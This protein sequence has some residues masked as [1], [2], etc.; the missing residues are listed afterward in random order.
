MPAEQFIFQPQ[1]SGSAVCKRAPETGVWACRRWECAREKADK[2]GSQP[3]LNTLWERS[4]VSIISPLKSTPKIH[5]HPKGN[6]KKQEGDRQNKTVEPANNHKAPRP[7]VTNKERARR[8]DVRQVVLV[9]EI[10]VLSA[11]HFTS[12]CLQQTPSSPLHTRAKRG[13]LWAFLVG[14]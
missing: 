14:I 1:S 13:S 3:N 6:R 8:L 9:R 7:Y 10:A 4:Q 5:G 12:C 2:A 11:A